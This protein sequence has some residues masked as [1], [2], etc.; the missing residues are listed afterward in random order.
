MKRLEFSKTVEILEQTH[1]QMLGSIRCMQTPN[2]VSSV[3][4][5]TTALMKLATVQY[6]I[7][8]LP[9]YRYRQNKYQHNNHYTKY[10][11]LTKNRPLRNSLTSNL[12]LYKRQNEPVQVLCRTYPTIKSYGSNRLVL[13]KKVEPES[14]FLLV[15]LEFYI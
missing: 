12:Y 13:A 7:H 6:I 1:H 4:H 5:T 10:T 15:N 2:E 8:K 14:T 9:P 3:P 11:H